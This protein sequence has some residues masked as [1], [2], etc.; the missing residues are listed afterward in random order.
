[1]STSERRLHQ[2]QQPRRWTRAADQP[3]LASADHSIFSGKRDQSRRPPTPGDAAATDEEDRLEDVLV[4]QAG[5]RDLVESWLPND[6]E[7][8]GNVGGGVDDPNNPEAAL[9]RPKR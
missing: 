4:M 8:E 9:S 6:P 1:M 2:H 5:V 7:E 3:S